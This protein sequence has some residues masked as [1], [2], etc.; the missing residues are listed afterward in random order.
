MA[1]QYIVP[2]VLALILLGA[3]KGKSGRRKPRR[4]P[5]RVV[6]SGR[7]LR[8]ARLANAKAAARYLGGR[9]RRVR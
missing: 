7:T 5:Y 1:L 9:V 2:A 3:G 4:W 8:Y 6:W